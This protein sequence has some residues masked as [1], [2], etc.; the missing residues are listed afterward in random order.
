MNYLVTRFGTDPFFVEW[1]I[2]KSH[3]VPGMI[4]YDLKKNLYMKHWKTW[5][6]IKVR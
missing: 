1:F 2:P 6:E 5:E 4:V 3:F